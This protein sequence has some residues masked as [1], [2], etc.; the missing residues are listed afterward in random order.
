MF[1][2]NQTD[3][4]DFWIS[5]KD[6]HF[7]MKAQFSRHIV[8]SDLLSLSIIFMTDAP[9]WLYPPHLL[10]DEFMLPQVSNQLVFKSIDLCDSGD[11]FYE[12]L[13]NVQNSFQL[14]IS[15]CLQSK[16]SVVLESIGDPS[17]TVDLAKLK[18]IQSEI[19]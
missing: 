5:L 6:A 19:V 12:Q 3:T 18:F 13:W 17:F 2:A 7:P 11:T 15:G 14:Q 10:T 1:V 9:Q 4:G 8:I 16:V